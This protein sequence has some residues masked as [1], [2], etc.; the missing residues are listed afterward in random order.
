MIW[1]TWQDSVIKLNLKFSKMLAFHGEK[2][3]QKCNS[4]TSVIASWC[5]IVWLKCKSVSRNLESNW[6]TKSTRLGVAEMGRTWLKISWQERRKGWGQRDPRDKD[7]IFV[8]VTTLKAVLSSFKNLVSIAKEEGGVL[9]TIRCNWQLSQNKAY[10]RQ[11]QKDNR[12][13][14]DNNDRQENQPDSW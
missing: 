4:C 8:L 12:D 10:W 7:A 14:T 9:K 6:I 13:G 3:I 2:H 11:L 5:G 1:L